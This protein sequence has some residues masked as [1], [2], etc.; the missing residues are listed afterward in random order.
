MTKKIAVLLILISVAGQLF[1]QTPAMSLEGSWH[2]TLDAGQKL[3]LVLT[4]SKSLDGAY[5]G[6]VDSLDQGASIPIEIIKVGC[7]SSR[8]YPASTQLQGRRLSGRAFSRVRADISS[9]GASGNQPAVAGREWLAV[10]GP[11]NTSKHQRALIPVR[12][13]THIAQRFAIDFMQLR[14]EGRT[15]AGDQKDNKN[16]RC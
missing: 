14:E 8:L 13:G 2:G 15:F 10:N 7:G 11:S 3:R 16:Y 9:D 12:G 1:D 6:K 4:V 5:A